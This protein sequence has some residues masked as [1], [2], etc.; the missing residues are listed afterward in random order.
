MTKTI[1]IDGWGDLQAYLIYPHFAML[2]RLVLY[3]NT[4]TSTIVW[5]MEDDRIMGVLEGHT[6]MVVASALHT[7]GGTAVTIAW[8]E[9]LPNAVKIWSL[10]T[11]K[12]TANLTSTSDASISLL[13]DRLLLG[14]SD[15]PIKV[16][17]IGGSAP[18]ALMDLHGHINGI[19]TITASDASNVALSG[20]CDMSMRLW[21]LRSGQCVRTMEEHENEINSVSMDSACRTA[22]SGSD[23][24]KAKL[25]D[26]GSGRCINTYE[27]DDGVQKVMMHESGGSFLL[28]LGEDHFYA[29]TTAPGHHVGDEPILHADLS[30][31]CTMLKPCPS[32]PAIAASKDLSRVGMCYVNAD[33]SGL[34]VCI[35][36]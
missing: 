8:M 22:V 15:G 32:A 35:W 25:W 36:K 28:A 12:C 13:K 33:E 10:E 18:V 16:W 27:H 26:L 4:K 29:W 17:D 30:S 20:S 6:N 19:T 34:R 7:T 21:D 31:I 1:R 9:S 2:D 14:S 23:D 11:V 3:P 5:D 24:G